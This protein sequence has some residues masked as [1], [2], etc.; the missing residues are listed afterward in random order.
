MTSV[1]QLDRKGKH[2]RPRRFGPRYRRNQRKKKFKTAILLQ[3]AFEAALIAF[4]A[5]IPERMG[6]ATDG[7]GILLTEGVK[8]SDKT[9]KKHQIYYYLDL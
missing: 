1:L 5:N 2:V 7:R 9:K 3:N 8:V 4:L 6:Y